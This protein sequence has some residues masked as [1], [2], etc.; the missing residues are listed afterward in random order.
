MLVLHEMHSHEYLIPAVFK[1]I[2]MHLNSHLIII[3]F[4]LLGLQSNV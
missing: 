4:F 2:P 3:K 1:C